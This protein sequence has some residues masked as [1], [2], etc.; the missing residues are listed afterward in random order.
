MENGEE[1]K[2]LITKEA[3][4]Q[5]KK[6]LEKR[7]TPGSYLRVGVRGGLCKGFG[8]VLEFYDKEPREK[9][10]VFELDGVKV[11]IDKKS[12]LYINGTELGYK[13]ELM[14]QGF[15]FNNPLETGKCGCQESFSI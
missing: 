13:K 6:A 3:A 12:I 9:D 7:G 15:T 11:V 4:K 8:Y 10:L 1:Y 5:I 2:F 14:K